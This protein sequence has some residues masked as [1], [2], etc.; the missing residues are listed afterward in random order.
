MYEGLDPRTIS[1]I[2]EIYEIDIVARAQQLREQS[3]VFG[4]VDRVALD[5]LA[6]GNILEATISGQITEGLLVVEDRLIVASLRAIDPKE[7]RVEFTILEDSQDDYSKKSRV[8]NLSSLKGGS[9]RKNDPLSNCKPNSI[10]RSKGAVVDAMATN[11][12]NEA[13]I[14]FIPGRWSHLTI[15]GVEFF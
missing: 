15:N 11:F 2:D 13:A 8:V 9:G 5:G 10:E 3:L 14:D 4:R 12:K 1:E 6:Y 7:K